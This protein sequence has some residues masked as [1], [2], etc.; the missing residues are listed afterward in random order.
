MKKY[1]KPEFNLEA[2]EENDVIQTSLTVDPGAANGNEEGGTWDD[3]F[4]Q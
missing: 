3:I 2:I 1:L 4:N